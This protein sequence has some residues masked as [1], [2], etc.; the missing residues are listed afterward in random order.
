MI[1]HSFPKTVYYTEPQDITIF[2]TGFDVDRSMLVCRFGHKLAHASY[3]NDSA[4]VCPSPEGL[5]VGAHNV[6]VSNNLQDF[7]T[8]FSL[9]QVI[10]VS[11][12]FSIE[13]KQNV[14]WYAEILWRE[15][16]ECAKGLT[17]FVLCAA[18]LWIVY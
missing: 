7:S 11:R 2:G 14:I 13:P 17:I 12:V 18:F 3:K 16:R 8:T 10:G 5:S 6:T 1:S 9:L 4:L 15:C